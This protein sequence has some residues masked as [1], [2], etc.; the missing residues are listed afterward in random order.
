MNTF[1]GLVAA[2]ALFLLLAL[3]AL[4]G[5]RVELRIS[6]QIRAARA[7]ERRHEEQS[8]PTRSTFSPIA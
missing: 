3:P 2:T 1:L 8:A 7:A 4:I 6:R 5:F